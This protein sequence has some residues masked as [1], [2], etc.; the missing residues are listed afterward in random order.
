VL[1]EWTHTMRAEHRSDATVR[2]YT[3]SAQMLAD[4]LDGADAL[5]A[6]TDEP[7]RWTDRAAAEA[8]DEG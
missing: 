7:S 1:R 2:S 5:D 6:S 4:F 3:E 8:S